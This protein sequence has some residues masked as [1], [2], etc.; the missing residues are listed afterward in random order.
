MLCYTD[1]QNNKHVSQFTMLKLPFL[2]GLMTVFLSGCMTKPD[3]PF[4]VADQ[5]LHTRL[6]DDGS[7]LFAFIVT[8]EKQARVKLDTRKEI[9]RSEFK[10]FLNEEHIEDS[11]ALKLA[12]EE[13]AV[14]LLKTALGV[15]GY[16]QQGYDIEEV[17]W[18]ERKVQLR[19]QCR[20]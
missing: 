1:G 9:S 2:F 4:K 20:D 13:R 14:Q 3:E 10:M 6:A 16:C 15:Q 18:K 11:P 7:K 19:G 5:T 12:L 8:V 17:Y